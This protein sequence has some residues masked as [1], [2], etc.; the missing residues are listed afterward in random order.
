MHR[1]LT[2]ASLILLSLISGYFLGTHSRNP[3]PPV[4]ENHNQSVRQQDG[5]LFTNPLLE[6]ETGDNLANNPSLNSLRQDLQTEIDKLTQTKAVSALS[7]Y[8]R[9]LN[10]GPWFGLNENET[11]TPASLLKLTILIGYLQESERDQTTLTQSLTNDSGQPITIQELLNRMIIDSDN[12]ALELLLPHLP[13]GAIQEIH[14]DLSLP[15]LTSDQPQDFLSP[16][17]YAGLFRVLFNA[18]YLSR[19][20]SETALA[21]LAQS[22]Y[23]DG[24]V[25]GVDDNIRVAHKYGIFDPA[26]HPQQLHDCGIIYYPGHPYLLCIMT[27]GD[28]IPD[29]TKAI[30]SFS[31]LVFSE[32]KSQ[33][34]I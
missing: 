11:F 14:S 34:P 16:I 29:L 27:K 20:S 2:I 6:C 13:Q 9:D 1:L 5:S 10:N 4:I 18:S 32:I 24:L 12:Q 26:N 23:R 28:H 17:E 31:R 21:L 30:S 7:L 25:A 22:T 33:Y 19:I 8:Y 3:S 15:Y